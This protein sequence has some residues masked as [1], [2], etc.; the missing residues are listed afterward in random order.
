M[1]TLL[2]TGKGECESSVGG[3]EGLKE[4]KKGVTKDTCKERAKAVCLSSCCE[5]A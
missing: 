5:M 1:A 4:G 3:W 2:K